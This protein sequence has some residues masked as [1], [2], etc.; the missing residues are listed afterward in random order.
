MGFLLITCARPGMWRAGVQHPARAVY[1]SSHFD[2]VQLEQILADPQFVITSADTREALAETLAA[3]APR[4]STESPAQRRFAL[5]VMRLLL[6]G[7]DEPLIMEVSTAIQ[8]AVDTLM[9]PDE[10]RLRAEEIFARYAMT[11]PDEEMPGEGR[12]GT[13]REA[14]SADSGPEAEAPA[15]ATGG[16]QPAAPHITSPAAVGDPST[17]A[18]GGELTSPP[19][20]EPEPRARKTAKNKA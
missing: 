20:S 17:E 19:P 14:P 15:D 10:W 4:S 9:S 3:T 6:P 2:E 18:G 11:P 12:S 16:V 1:P 7:A 13:A 8:E 5:S